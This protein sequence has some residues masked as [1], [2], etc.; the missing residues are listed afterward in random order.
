MSEANMP[1]K[2]IENNMVVRVK[3]DK[4][5]CWRNSLLKTN[6]KASL[7][8]ELSLK[9][10]K[11]RLEK[12]TTIL[13]IF[14]NKDVSIHNV[15]LP[16]NIASNHLE[17]V[18]KYK[19]EEE[20][21]EDINDL[22]FFIVSKNENSVTLAIISKVIFKKWQK[23]FCEID[24]DKVICIPDFWLLP[25]KENNWSL[26][27]EESYCLFRTNQ[28]VGGCWSSKNIQAYLQCSLNTTAKPNTITVY[29]DQFKIADKLSNDFHISVEKVN[30]SDLLDFPIDINV[31][32]SAIKLSKL[33]LQEE[34][35]RIDPFIIKKWAS[36]G[37]IMGMLV[38]AVLQIADVFILKSSEKTFFDKKKLIL[39]E[40]YPDI[41]DP[42][43][44]E[45]KIKYDVDQ[46]KQRS[47]N[48]FFQLF[49]QTGTVLKKIEK[50]KIHSMQYHEQ[51]LTLKLTLASF[52][53]LSDLITKLKATGLLVEQKSAEKSGE[54]IEAELDVYV[55]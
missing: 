37:I 18:A 17:T 23:L 3:N 46:F 13:F 52:N 35:Q 14:N 19:I 27:V 22:L 55:K 16:Q 26:M 10:I 11:D 42:A 1:E 48:N 39:K 28:Y 21:C 6:I 50:D 8:H 43:E 33:D 36:V 2:T 5:I 47:I 45:E 25:H 54:T 53:E 4:M 29:N 30:I 49:L 24:L 32:P 44:A 31:L 9:P 34:K 7:I 41:T 15:E 51:K 12:A 38:F 40:I 20:L